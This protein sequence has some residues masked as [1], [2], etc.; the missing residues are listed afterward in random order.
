MD[1]RLVLDRPG[2]APCALQLPVKIRS[3]LCLLIKKISFNHHSFHLYKGEVPFLQKAIFILHAAIL[4]EGLLKKRLGTGFYLGTFLIQPAGFLYWKIKTK[5]KPAD[6]CGRRRLEDPAGHKPEEAGK[7][8]HGRQRKRS[9]RHSKK[10]HKALTK[11]ILK[12]P[13]A[14][15]LLPALSQR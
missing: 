14:P 15:V 5:Q 13:A 11:P 3:R 10:Q 2:V 7:L 12:P 8:L 4:H 1:L 6:S 9:R